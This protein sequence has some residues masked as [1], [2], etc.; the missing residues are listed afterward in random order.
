MCGRFTL[1]SEPDLVTESFEVDLSEIGAYEPRFNIAPQ[2]EILTLVERDAQRRV[3]TMRWGL[4][5][6]W[7]KPLAKL[8]NMINARIETLA[9]KPAYREPFRR[10]R[11]A[12]V[13]DGFYEWQGSDK[14]KPKQPYWIHRRDRTPFL[15]AGVWD[16]W[17]G[18]DEEQP[19]LISCSIVTE[20]ANAAVAGIH[21]RMPVILDPRAITPWLSADNDNASERLLALL[22]PLEAGMLTSYPVSTQVN[23]PA[24]EEPGLIQETQPEQASLF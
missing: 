8:P 14:G 21:P 7:A 13:A 4:V 6:H 16:R 12:I 24:A 20:A 15:M 22:E 11:C 23:D 9:E 10:R 3:A 1:H 2:Q 17:T 19:P 5:P 18:G